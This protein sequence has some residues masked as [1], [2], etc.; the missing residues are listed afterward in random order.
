MELARPWVESP[1]FGRFLDE[2]AKTDAQR[3]LA[4]KYSEDGY[5]LIDDVVSEATAR[6]IK[7]EVQPLFRPDV[8]DG[9]RS[10]NRVQDAWRE[11]PACR[12]LASEPRVL[13]TLR[14]LYGRR[15]IPFQT[16]NFHRGTEQRGHS[17]VIHFNSIPK[18]FMCGV[19]VA[20]E[21]I[22]PDQGPLFYYSR[23]HHLDEY[24][25]ADLGLPPGVESYRAYEDFIERLVAS[26]DHAREELVIPRGTALV[27]SANLIHGGSPIRNP[28]TTRWSQV[29]H[30]FFE[31][32]I[33]YGP[34]FSDMVTGELDLRD[35]VDVSTGQP[36]P[37]SHGGRPVRSFGGL[38]PRS[39]ISTGDLPVTMKVNAI[40]HQSARRLRP[41]MQIPAVRELARKLATA[42]TRSG[43][44]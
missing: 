23:S 28:A 15:P 29:T 3:A 37:H 12:A 26:T 8:P 17:D 41:L 5:C 30:Y 25:L 18:R 2:H 21:D 6:A 16:L 40:L 20:L 32:C 35:V 9:A 33:Y 10:S 44:L 39:W 34:L 19:W 22:G 43:R 7:D 14:F 42:S 36:V 4:R 24:T 11:S 38:R 1:F 31:D 13:E 27:W